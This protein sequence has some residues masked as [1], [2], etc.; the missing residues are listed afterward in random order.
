MALALP[1][2]PGIYSQSGIGGYAPPP[3]NAN[4]VALTST[5]T[6]L[7]DVTTGATTEKPHSI[8]GAVNMAYSPNL[9]RLVVASTVSIGVSG[10]MYYSDDRGTTWTKCPAGPNWNADD[11]WLYVFFNPLSRRFFGLSWRTTGQEMITSE[12]GINWTQLGTFASQGEV[13]ANWCSMDVDVGTGTLCIGIYANSIFRFTDPTMRSFV[14]KP[15]AGLMGN[16]IVVLASR[17]NGKWVSYGGTFTGQ[18]QVQS[19][20]DGQ[21]WTAGVS[22]AAGD[23]PWIAAHQGGRAYVGHA[24]GVYSSADLDT[25]PW[26]LI[27]GSANPICMVSDKMAPRT[28]HINSGGQVRMLTDG[29]YPAALTTLAAGFGSMQRGCWVTY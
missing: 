15:D 20:N 10:G 12:D 14:R 13:V 5:K 29:T 7:I 26:S 4:F 1:I 27:A 9:D 3:L 28:L 22:A 25:T 16:A 6:I 19:V 2:I 24:G 18:A 23:A 8:P 21:T 11:S 17:G